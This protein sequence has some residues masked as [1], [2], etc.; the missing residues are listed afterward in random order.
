M[1]TRDRSAST[2]YTSNEV[3]DVDVRFFETTAIAYGDET[4]T[5]SDGSSVDLDRYLLYRDD[6]W[7]IVAAQ[8]VEIEE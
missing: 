5:K 8:D 4:W 6:Q 1:V 7:Q 3:N 2:I